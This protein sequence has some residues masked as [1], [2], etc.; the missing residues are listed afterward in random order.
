MQETVINS[1][2]SDYNVRTFNW[3][4]EDETS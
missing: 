2:H 4:R 3:T 1:L